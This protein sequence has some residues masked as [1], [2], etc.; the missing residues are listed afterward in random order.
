MQKKTKNIKISVSISGLGVGE[1]HAHHIRKNKDTVLVS[2]F[3]PDLNRL[4][5]KEKKFKIKASKSFND[6][7]L[8]DKTKMIV[9]ASPDHFHCKQIIESLKKKKHT[10]TEKPICNNL[11]E[12][13]QIVNQW[14]KNKKLKLRANLILRSSPLFIWLK[15]KIQGGFFGT[16]YSI[17]VEYLYG[18]LNRF[19]NGWRGN[20]KEYSPINGGGAHMIDLACWLINELPY[21][22]ASNSSNIAT[23]QFKLKSDDHFESTLKFKSGIILRAV[24]NLACVYNHQ[25]IVKIYGTKK[26]FVYDD[27]GARIYNS[28]NVKNN[29]N[30][31]NMQS[32]PSNKINIIKEFI[33]DIKKN[34]DNIKETL[35]DL[36]IMNVLCY[37]NISA[38]KNKKQQIKYII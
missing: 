4:I 28:R 13:K 15:K 20:S 21:E 14:A 25:H 1:K 36:R 31:T 18:R 24:A 29:F 17:D 23:K 19:T 10:F 33:N 16:V 8:D 5:K 12:L 3:D 27:L 22:V 6:M 9:V 2:F 32:L 34:K 30:K 7:L 37:C 35:F 38:K 26:T 11:K